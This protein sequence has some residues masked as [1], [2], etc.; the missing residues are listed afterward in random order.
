[1]TFLTHPSSQLGSLPAHEPAIAVP[2][3][4]P[5]SSSVPLPPYP[6]NNILP[7]LNTK[8]MILSL[9]YHLTDLYTSHPFPKWAL[10]TIETLGFL[11]FG[12]LF[13]FN[14]ADINQMLGPYYQ[15]EAAVLLAYNSGVWIVCL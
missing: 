4:P 8:Q 3:P 2:S 15:S 6:N 10:G 5:P 14:C 7:R 13:G 11:I 1:M 12:T 9:A